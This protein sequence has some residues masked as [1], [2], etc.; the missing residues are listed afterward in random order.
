MTSKK[1]KTTNTI[2]KTILTIESFLI[3]LSSIIGN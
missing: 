1:I 2:K 3:K